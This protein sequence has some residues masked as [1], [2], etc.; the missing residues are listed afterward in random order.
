MFL[1]KEGSV[2]SKVP[3]T[4]E[5]SME[6]CERL[7]SRDQITYTDSITTKI[8]VDTVHCRFKL[9]RDKIDSYEKAF[10]GLESITFKM[11]SDQ[12]CAD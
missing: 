5:R 6:E 7:T 3:Y 11:T 12:V 1:W 4:R 10:G 8:F 9:T 2:L